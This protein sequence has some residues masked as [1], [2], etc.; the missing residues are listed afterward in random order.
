[1]RTSPHALTLPAAAL[2]K[3]KAK[4]DGHEANGKGDAEGEKKEAEEFGSAE[5]IRVAA[6]A[7][8]GAA[9]V[10]ARVMAEKEDRVVQ[11]LVTQAVEVRLAASLSVSLSASLLLRCGCARVYNTLPVCDG[12]TS[13]DPSFAR[14]RSLT[15]RPRRCS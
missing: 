12:S 14:V 9:A 2:L 7:A 3:E 5:N 13:T 1:M 6:A 15:A 11:R 4:Q 10:K 8:L